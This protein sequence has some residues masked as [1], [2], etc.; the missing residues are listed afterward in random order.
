MK[1][2]RLGISEGVD[3]S[4]LSLNQMKNVL[5]KVLETESYARNAK[6]WSERFRDQKEKPLDRAIW[7]VEWVI[8][9]PNCDYLISPVHRLGFIASNAYDIIACIT[10]ILMILTVITIKIGCYLLKTM[11]TKE[12]SSIH[13]KLE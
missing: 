11:F 6:K 13:T 12:K 9:N 4:S 3:Y 2:K 5:K 1:T 7:H 8:R 10:L